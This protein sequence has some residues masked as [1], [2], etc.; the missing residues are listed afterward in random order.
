MAPRFAALGA[1]AWL[2]AEAAGAPAGGGAQA[3]N[4]VAPSAVVPTAAKKVRRESFF[5]PDR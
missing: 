3:A 5:E 4:K 2:P 1:A